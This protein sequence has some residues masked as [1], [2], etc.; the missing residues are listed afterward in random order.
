MAAASSSAPSGVRSR[1]ST[2]WVSGSP[3]RALNSTTRR[4]AR[5]QGQ[6]DVEHA[7]ERRPA[8]AI[9]STVGWATALDDLVDEVL[10]RPG[11]RRVGAHAAG[12]RARV[13]VAERA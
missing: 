13:A 7:G 8:A 1:A 9:S 11:Q 12:V 3:K 5:G 2:T 6:A 10:R 4:P